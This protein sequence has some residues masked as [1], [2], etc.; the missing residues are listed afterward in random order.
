MRCENECF[1]IIIFFS[2]LCDVLDQYSL[3][4]N[5]DRKNM[6]DFWIPTVKI[7]ILMIGICWVIF[8]LQIVRT[9]REQ[10]KN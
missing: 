8:F 2:R 5:F 6:G 3:A 4:G 9:R 1:I 7:E 10:K